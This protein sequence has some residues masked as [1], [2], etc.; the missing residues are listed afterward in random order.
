[1][2][3]AWEGRGLRTPAHQ[4][5][6]QRVC[7]GSAPRPA[8]RTVPATPACLLPPPPPPGAQ[9]WLNLDCAVFMNRCPLALT[10]KDVDSGEYLF[11]V[12]AWHE[13]LLYSAAANCLLDGN[14]ALGPGAHHPH[15]PQ[16]QQQPQQPPGPAAATP[17]VGAKLLSGMGRIFSK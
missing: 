5:V 11:S 4:R 6:Q 12:L 13:R 17:G 1:M 16:Q 8:P 10:V 15:Q 2:P 14:Y 7:G 9:G 3:R